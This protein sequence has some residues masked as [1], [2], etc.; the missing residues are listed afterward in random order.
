MS[1]TIETYRGTV[2][3]WECDANGHMNVRF[4]VGKFD[5]GTWQFM[6]QIGASREELK[7]RN[8][9]P[10]AVSQNIAY[11]RELVPGDTVAVHSAV[12]ALGKSSC[13]FRHVMTDIASGEVVAEMEL[14]G[15]FVDLASRKATPVWPELRAKA[16]A[17]LAAPA[18]KA[19]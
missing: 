11:K 5:E 16:E 15:V 3:P 17:L 1:S 9:G 18:E 7:G 10:M 6:A 13:R 4:Y 2:F 8:C 19:A 12:V 14:V